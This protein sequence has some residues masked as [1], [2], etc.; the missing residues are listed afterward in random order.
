[1]L[2]GHSEPLKGEAPTERVRPLWILK[3]LQQTLCVSHMVREICD[4]SRKDNWSVCSYQKY[5]SLLD[6]GAMTVCQTYA[7]TKL[8]ELP[9]REGKEARGWLTSP[10]EDAHEST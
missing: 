8:V 4:D 5:K 6:E 2:E 9:I 3:A 7:E 10:H 1:M